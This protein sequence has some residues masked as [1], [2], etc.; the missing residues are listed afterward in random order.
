MNT[1]IEF[2]NNFKADD[3]VLIMFDWNGQ[4]SKD[5]VDRNLGFRRQVLDYFIEHKS[6][7][8]LD[9][10][11]VLYEA[12]TELSREAWAIHP[13]VSTLA[14]ELL[15]RGRTKYIKEYLLGM[16]CG[17]DAYICVRMIKLSAASRK[18]LLE[19]C[20]TYSL[21]TDGFPSHEVI[22]IFKGFLLDMPP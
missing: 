13:V 8:C 18:E 1:I 7:F 19:Y 2:V 10:I 22:E 17:M 5:F 21:D 11:C 12:E 6:E 14:Q 9:L 3:A 16:G 15:E 20:D 4:H